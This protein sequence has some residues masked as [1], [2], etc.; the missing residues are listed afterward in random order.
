[1]VGVMSFT[2]SKLSPGTVNKRLR[3]LFIVL[4]SNSEGKRKAVELVGILVIIGVN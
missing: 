1:M 4:T 3:S 2:E